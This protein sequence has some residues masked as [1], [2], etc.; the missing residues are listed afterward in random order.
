V[1]V[2]S[3]MDAHV[4]TNSGPLSPQ[5]LFWE[6]LHLVVSRTFGEVEGGGVR[7]HFSCSF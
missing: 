4:L 2:F 7:S 6:T 1:V 3:V 5:P